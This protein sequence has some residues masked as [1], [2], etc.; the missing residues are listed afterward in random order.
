MNNN[1]IR[2]ILVD[3]HQV[4]LEGLQY[5]LKDSPELEVVAEAHNGQELLDYLEHTSVLPDLIL[6]DIEMP[7]MDGITA[8]RTVKELYPQ[9][10]VIMLTMVDSYAA[11]NQSRSFGADGF[12]SKNHGRKAIIDAIRQ[13]YYNGEFVI[14]ANLNQAQSSE[15]YFNSPTELVADQV[16]LTERERQI[17]I[18]LYHQITVP[19]IAKKLNLS[20]VALSIQLKVLFAKLHVK[21]TE[22]AVNQ[23]LDLGIMSATDFATPPR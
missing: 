21:T 1:K 18:L 12:I 15:Q 4:L 16:H 19:E 13:V 20:A 10:K 3:D 5:L 11:L 14:Q 7:V 17:L 2:V 23:V 9:L 6:M 22:A 8:T